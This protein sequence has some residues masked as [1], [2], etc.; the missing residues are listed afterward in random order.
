MEGEITPKSLKAAVGKKVEVLAFG[1]AYIGIL[2]RVDL[3][4]GT[5]QIRDHGDCVVLEIERI[6]NFK[7]LGL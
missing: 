5:I 2:K 7:V 3:E 1:M 6:E 4:P